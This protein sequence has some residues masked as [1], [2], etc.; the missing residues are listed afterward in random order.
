MYPKSLDFTGCRIIPPKCSHTKIYNNLH[1]GSEN[2]KLSIVKR[3]RREAKE[4]EILKLGFLEADV[5]AGFAA[6]HIS[7]NLYL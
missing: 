2:L 1:L 5:N 4:G 3:Q 6:D 7:N